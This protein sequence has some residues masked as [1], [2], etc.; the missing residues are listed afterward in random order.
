MCKFHYS[1]IGTSVLLRGDV[2]DGALGERFLVHY[3]IQ[4]WQRI[5]QIWGV[6]VVCILFSS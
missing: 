5:A 3:Q 4:L 6:R 1:K 2:L